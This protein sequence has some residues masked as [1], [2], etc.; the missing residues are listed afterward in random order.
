DRGTVFVLPPRVLND[1]IRDP[2]PSV[3]DH[4]DRPFP[5][6][7]GPCDSGIFWRHRELVRRLE[8]A[9]PE[10]L[11]PLWCEVTAL[12]L[13]ADVLKA[14]FARHHLPRKRRRR[15][16]DADHADRIE[17][18]KTYLARRLG[19]RITLDEVARA[20]HASP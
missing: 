13:L 14:A 1:I 5:F 20:V 2:D 7:T 15:G 17:A 12:Q 8:S 3:V 18:V 4:P 11:E 19:E 9:K 16:T 6:V 10:R